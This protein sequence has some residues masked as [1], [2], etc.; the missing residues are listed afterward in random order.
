MK[1]YGNAT[2]GSVEV[3]D[4]LLKKIASL[5]AEYAS[6]LKRNALVESFDAKIEYK[7]KEIEGKDLVL[8]GLNISI[9]DKETRNAKLD[10]KFGKTINE[11][12]KLKKE[13]AVLLKENEESNEKFVRSYEI[14]VKQIKVNKDIIKDQ[15]QEIKDNTVLI[16]EQL[17]VI[18]INNK[19]VDASKIQSDNEKA[20]LLVQKKLVN[21][22]KALLDKYKKESIIERNILSE[23]KIEIDKEKKDIA[24]KKEGIVNYAKSVD[25]DIKKKQVSVLEINANLNRREMLIKEK[26]IQL[27]ERIEQ[28]EK[29]YDKKF[30]I[31]LDDLLK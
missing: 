6:K 25:Q 9:F 10:E 30:N 12:E 15:E 18:N 4:D 31:I 20:E 19:S 14:G 27:K 22:E 11:I 23:I 16:K 24:T 28:S 13:K 3:K 26:A 1:A 2:I 5:E 7:N 8:K 21:E 17:K 29:F